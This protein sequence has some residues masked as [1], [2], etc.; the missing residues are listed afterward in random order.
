MEFLRK[1]TAYTNHKI[2]TTGDK[3]NR[4]LQILSFFDVVSLYC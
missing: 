4:K 2:W 3:A 1:Q